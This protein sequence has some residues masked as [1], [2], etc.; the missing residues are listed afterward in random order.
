MSA[1]VATV[2]MVERV[3][4]VVAAGSLGSGGRTV[5]MVEREGHVVGFSG[6]L[7]RVRVEAGAACGCCG[8]RARCGSAGS[9]SAAQIVELALPAGLSGL[10]IGDRVSVATPSANVARA[11][12]LGY[13]LPAAC[14]VL[15]AALAG[16]EGNDTSAALGAVA[17]L[18]VGLALVRLI[19]RSASAR[20]MGLL[21][22]ADINPGEC[23]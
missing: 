7:T 12:L 14:L 4:H 11:A 10:A 15:G 17:G 20:R 23:S 6:A 2:D 9:S 1:P 19:S 22:G 18:M 8:S 13:L 3:G 5:D 21:A 16:I